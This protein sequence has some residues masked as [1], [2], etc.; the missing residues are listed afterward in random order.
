MPVV[1]PRADADGALGDGRRKLLRR[2]ML[3]DPV[4]EPQTLQPRGCEDDGLVAVLVEALEPCRN[5]AAQL[6]Q[7]QVVAGAGEKSAPPQ[8]AGTDARTGWQLRECGA[9]AADE[10]VTRI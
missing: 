4:L 6:E 1:R 5:V 2:K 10:C 8:A 3:G 9:R 7:R